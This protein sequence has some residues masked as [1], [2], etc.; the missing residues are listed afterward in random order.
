MIA[1]ELAEALT[2]DVLVPIE[3][4][5]VIAALLPTVQRLIA[6]AEK[7]AEA[8]V[9][10]ADAAIVVELLQRVGGDPDRWTAEQRRAVM[11]LHARAAA[12]DPQ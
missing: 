5:P 6:D 4:G 1:D 3:R 10:S 2:D 9:T 11:H 12:L 8:A 7:P